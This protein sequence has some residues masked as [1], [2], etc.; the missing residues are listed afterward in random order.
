RKTKVQAAL[1]HGGRELAEIIREVQANHE[2][3][4][5][6]LERLLAELTNYFNDR[7]NLVFARV[8]EPTKLQ[9]RKQPQ[10][11]NRRTRPSLL[12]ASKAPRNGNGIGNNSQT[13]EV[14]WTAHHNQQPMPTDL[15]RAIGETLDAAYIN[16][17]VKSAVPRG[18]SLEDFKT[19]TGSDM[20]IQAAITGIKTQ[21]WNQH[22]STQRT[23]KGIEHELSE[24]DGV[25]LRGDLIVVPSSLR[26]QVLALAHTGHL[27]AE[28]TLQRLQTKVWWPGV[29][30]DCE[31]FVQAC[32]PCQATSHATY[33]APLRPTKIPD[34]A[35]LLLGMDFYGPI[36]GQMLLV[37]TDLATGK[38]PAE[39][40]M[41]R[42]VN[43][44]IPSVRPSRRASW[45]T[46]DIKN[47]HNRYNDNMKAGFDKTKRVRQHSIRPGD[48]VLRRQNKSKL[49]TPFELEPWVVESV[50]GDTFTLQRQGQSCMRHLV[51]IRPVSQPLHPPEAAAGQPP[52]S[53]GPAEADDGESI[54]MRRHPR[55][56]RDAGYRL[57]GGAQS[58]SLRLAD[59]LGP[60]RLRLGSPVA[61]VE[62]V[63]ASSS[64]SADAPDGGARLAV[65][66]SS[67]DRLLARL[68]IAAVPP[69]QLARL[70]LPSSEPA[71]VSLQTAVG[72]AVP[73]HYA[74]F[75]VTYSEAWWRRL[76]YSGELFSCDPLSPIVTGFDGTTD[77]GSAALV[78][79]SAGRPSQDLECLPTPEARREAV[80]RHLAKFF[81][82]DSASGLAADCLHFAEKF[83]R[84]EP[85]NGGCPSDVAP[86]GFGRFHLADLAA[87]TAGLCDG[88]LLFAGTEFARRWVGY[89][90]GAIES[91]ERAATAAATKL[92]DGQDG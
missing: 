23:F 2:D 46:S 56:A 16:A 71:A 29:R 42:R 34:G 84:A 54:A 74:K 69:N 67:G 80:L 86:C 88:R 21:H 32:L 37:T 50:K 49:H 77:T 73:S 19:A 41:G 7:K 36:Q 25:L 58:L 59:R 83:W 78:L 28:R 39:L 33:H 20:D 13:E 60:G 26:R 87:A 51:H 66:L 17:V 90:E 61:G 31:A 91:G 82:H 18:L 10:S 76:G 24:S 4:K 72:A 12:S 30:A 15:S 22:S 65:R 57:V 9:K 48:R 53:A 68:V 8:R 64:A 89:M 79:L 81:P 35:W 55:R 92:E 27:S 38:A 70:A 1:L 44:V 45:S 62:E 47:R 63:E 75:I 40:L 14:I 3:T 43:D 85:F 5:E 6:S 52:A 11:S